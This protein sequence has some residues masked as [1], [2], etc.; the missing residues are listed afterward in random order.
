[1][2]VKEL[3]VERVFFGS[4]LPG[5]SMGTELSKVLG[6]AISDREKELIFSG[7]LR[8]LLAPI[9]RRKGLAE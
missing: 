6:A 8:R 5:R 7:N 2:A 4:H 1:M 9:L 3:G